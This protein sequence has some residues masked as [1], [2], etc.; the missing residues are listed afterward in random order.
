MQNFNFTVKIFWVI[1]FV[2]ISSILVFANQANIFAVN[3][4]VGD[5]AANS[6]L[7]I[8][9]KSFNLLVGNYSRVGFNHPGPAILFVLALGEWLFYDLL[10][11]VPSPFSGQLVAVCFYNSYWICAICLL[12]YRKFGNLEL[13]IL[14]ISAF[15][16]ASTL[17]EHP[18]F[19]GIWM[20]YLYYFPFSTA[21]IAMVLFLEGRSDSLFNLALASGILMNGH[22][23]FIPIICFLLIFLSVYNFKYEHS[24]S[25]FRVISATFLKANTR[26]FFL[27]FITFSLFFIPLFINTIKHFPG[28]IGDYAKYS[29]TGVHNSFF[30]VLKFVSV[31]WGGSL[32]MLLGLTVSVLL[33]R[34][35][36]STE[37]KAS[38]IN[39]FP[40][41]I[42]A[43][44]L[45]LIL[46][47]KFG[48]D[49]LDM[50]YIGLF[51]Y[52]VPALLFAILAS[53]LWRK[54][55]FGHSLLMLILIITFALTI[56]FKQIKKADSMNGANYSSPQIPALYKAVKV[57]QNKNGRIVLDL[58]SSSDWEYLWAN[59]AGLGVYAK[60]SE[61]NLFCI[62]KNWHILF[63]QNLAC[64]QDELIENKKYTVSRDRGEPVSQGE[65]KAGGIL[66]K[67][68]SH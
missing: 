2:L 36:L 58:N 11:L 47:A 4:E 35:K 50:V 34:I 15:V 10:S 5:Y 18:L 44:T 38:K 48:V 8:D 63:T 40:V 51:Y 17:F 19:T 13:T 14:T 59:V 31:Y 52:S 66:F 39:G 27:A 41:V 46:Y 12:L 25:G 23:S 3:F 21:I 54:K 37:I 55:F 67:E 28:P 16:V 42:F 30:Q 68:V 1:L 57:N 29:S 45:A 65:F 22:V 7:I 43:V 53:I 32:P 62:N 26:Q 6:S 56:A 20:P 24:Q 61:D 60:R 33:L 9:A 49:H 64:R